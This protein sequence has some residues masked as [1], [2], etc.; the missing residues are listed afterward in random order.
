MRANDR[1]ARSARSSRAAHSESPSAESQSNKRDAKIRQGQTTHSCRMTSHSSSCQAC[2]PI[3]PVA[4][5]WGRWTALSVQN[6]GE[7]ASSRSP[8]V[9]GSISPTWQASSSH[10]SGK[11]AIG[12]ERVGDRA[13]EDRV[14]TEPVAVALVQRPL[15]GLAQ[16]LGFQPAARARPAG[17]SAPIRPTRGPA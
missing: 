1:R 8:A 16:G 5:I 4:I 14:F 7:A 6:S 11:R 15:I 13:G 17:G 9:S 3:H 10:S 2:N 12:L